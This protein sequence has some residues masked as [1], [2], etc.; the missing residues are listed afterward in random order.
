MAKV[1]CSTKLF[2]GIFGCS[3]EAR[4]QSSKHMYSTV[5]RSYFALSP[6]QGEGPGDKARSYLASSPAQGKGPGKEARSYLASF[7][8][9]WGRG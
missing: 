6:A 2:M 7:P 1:D 9:A 8:G 4:E 3:Y 5:A